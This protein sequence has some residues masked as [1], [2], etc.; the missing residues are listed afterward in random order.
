MRAIPQSV[1]APQVISSVTREVVAQPSNA[2]PGVFLKL[3]SYRVQDRWQAHENEC[4]SQAMWRRWW[5][6]NAPNRLVSLDRVADVPRTF[7][8]GSD[9]K[10]NRVHG[11]S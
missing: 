8:S 9:R 4:L 3:A 11:S 7:L 1:S 5:V 10:A 2:F 6:S